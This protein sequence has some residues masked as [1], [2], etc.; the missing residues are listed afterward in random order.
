M[1][2]VLD[3][4]EAV[5]DF[6]NEFQTV[7]E[8]KNRVTAF[9]DYPIQMLALDNI[10]QSTLEECLNDDERRAEM[11][12]AIVDRMKKAGVLWVG[13]ERTGIQTEHLR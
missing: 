3:R 9:M 8:Q 13:A 7:R 5:T 1:W 4:T 10:L 2:H 12:N 6:S 11:C